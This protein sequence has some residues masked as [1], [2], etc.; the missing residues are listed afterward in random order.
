MT[1]KRRL[2]RWTM[3]EN[4][5]GDFS[6]RVRGAYAFEKAI[7]SL[8]GCEYEPGCPIGHPG[9]G[10]PFMEKAPEGLVGADYEPVAY[11]G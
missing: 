2:T 7:K 5:R 1:A 8:G 11:N 3:A 9:P 6:M 10:F 4:K